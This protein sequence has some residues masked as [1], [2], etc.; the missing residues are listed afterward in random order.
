M[1]RRQSMSASIT[2]RAALT[3]AAGL[4][5]CVPC[6]ASA[7]AGNWPN[8][9][10]RLVIP[11]PPG[12]LADSFARALAEGLSERLKQSVIVDNRPGGSLIIGTDAVAKAPPDGYT[13]LL[14]SVS[15]LAINTGAFKKLPYDPI[16][17][18][19]P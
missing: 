8:R 7:Q 3:A 13:L 19:A 2:R 6:A 11:Y 12:G 17:D 15:G 18:F 10:I 4:L 9:P 1:T 14:G 5:A 16:R